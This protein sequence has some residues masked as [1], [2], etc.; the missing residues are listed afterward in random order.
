M[1]DYDHSFDKSD[2]IAMELNE[3]DKKLKQE[4]SVWLS[5]SPDK[6][7]LIASSTLASSAQQ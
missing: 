5:T 3:S 2:A 6:H 4:R 7:I 1:S